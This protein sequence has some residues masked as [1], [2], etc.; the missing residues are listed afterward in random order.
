MTV[1]FF[2]EG[3][4]EL[5]YPSW[6]LAEPLNHRSSQLTGNVPS[7]C[8]S[9]IPSATPSAVSA[10]PP[11]FNLDSPI[12][13]LLPKNFFPKSISSATLCRPSRM[14]SCNWK[15]IRATA[16][17]RFRRSP[18]ASRFWARNPIVAMRSLSFLVSLARGW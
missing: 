16:S 2:V 13:C 5:S 7:T 9:W 3:Y 15:A 12:T 8:T 1:S 17:G 6:T 10:C 11:L 14:N 4:L 18:L